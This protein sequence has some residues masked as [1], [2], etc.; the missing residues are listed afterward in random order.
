L[1]AFPP[2]LESC[3]VEH[4]GSSGVDEDT[5]VAEGVRV[6]IRV[7]YRRCDG[8]KH[9]LAAESATIRTNM[10]AGWNIELL[11]SDEPERRNRQTIDAALLAWA[12]LIAGATA[13]V[14]SS[15]PGQDADVAQAL[16]TILGWADP[17]WR[18]T[19]LGALVLA[20]VIV[21][22]VI[23]RQRWRL[24]RDVLAALLI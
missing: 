13:V 24:L 22:A 3:S 16:I 6:S 19:F 12:A 5:R 18:V 14:S 21:V 8:G 15:A 20:V 1:I 2:S 4:V 7:G 17:L 9:V 10:A 11:T 23:Y